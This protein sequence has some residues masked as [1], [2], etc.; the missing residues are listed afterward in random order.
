MLST[1]RGFTEEE[2]AYFEEGAMRAYTSFITK[3]AASRSMSVDAMHEVAQGRVWTG[4]QAAERGLVD[5][6]GGLWKALAIAASMSD[7]PAKN[8]KS[9]R[10]QTLRERPSGLKLPF[11]GAS[12]QAAMRRTESG[13]DTLVVCDDVIASCGMA[14]APSLGLSSSLQ[15]L[16]VGP[17]LA[18]M[19]RQNAAAQILAD[20]L[21]LSSQLVGRSASLGS[22]PSAAIEWLGWAWDSLVWG[23][24]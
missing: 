22:T 20:W 18:H 16:G 6:T 9:I 7:I 8:L 11:G 21:T 12:A 2:S 5:H 1:S 24:D 17:L 14:S 4:R 3:A 13:D 19:I 23:W 15:A 10:M